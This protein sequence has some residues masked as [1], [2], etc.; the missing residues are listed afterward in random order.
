MQQP[1][2]TYGLGNHIAEFKPRREVF[3][4]IVFIGFG[5]FC[6]FVGA[7]AAL[8][9]QGGDRSGGVVVSGIGLLIV[10]A[11]V[12]YFVYRSR[13]GNRTLMVFQEGLA[14]GKKSE[15]PL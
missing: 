15:P 6:A 8:G 1:I 4:A 13:Q 5:L 7:I 2:E 12:G 11:V 3:A 9:P 10:M 14:Y